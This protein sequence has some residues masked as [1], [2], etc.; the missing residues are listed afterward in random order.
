MTG[1]IS[2]SPLFPGYERMGASDD[3]IK[4]QMQ[5]F[6]GQLPE[7]L[8]EFKTMYN[9][10]FFSQT[11]I[12][13]TSI[14]LGG[15]AIV[16]ELSQDDEHQASGP[17]I[18][19]ILDDINKLSAQRDLLSKMLAYINGLVYSGK[20]PKDVGETLLNDGTAINYCL[21]Q[22]ESI[23]SMLKSL[24]FE[25]VQ[26]FWGKGDLQYYLV[27]RSN[28]GDWR[29]ELVYY[30]AEYMGGPGGQPPGMIDTL[31]DQLKSEWN[32]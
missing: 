17:I 28:G 6:I 4:A 1:P 14:G 21:E 29:K 9:T 20:F 15:N 11:P 5:D 16:Y 32:K 24:K 13:P 8:Q 12:D 26:V 22:V 3:P 2:G 10:T 18:K 27:I 31:L 7:I 19:A 25:P 30:E 23:I